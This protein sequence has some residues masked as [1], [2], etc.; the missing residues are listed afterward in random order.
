LLINWICRF[1]SCPFWTLQYKFK[2][3]SVDSVSLL[4]FICWSSSIICFHCYIHI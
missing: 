2:L 3:D 1:S 4:Y